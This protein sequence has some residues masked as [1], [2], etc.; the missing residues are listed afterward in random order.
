MLSPT[1]VVNQTKLSRVPY[2]K[3]DFAIFAW[4]VILNYAYSPFQ[5]IRNNDYLK[6]KVFLELKIYFAISV[7]FCSRTKNP[8]T[9][10]GVKK[11]FTG[12][13]GLRFTVM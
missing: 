12:K 5:T 10:N 13:C 2:C 7:F 6:K 3:S 4:R 11:G 8:R 9:V 1:T